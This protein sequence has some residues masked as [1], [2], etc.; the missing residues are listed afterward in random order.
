MKRT[1]IICCLLTVS[2]IHNINCQT[3]GNLYTESNADFTMSMPA[4]WQ[5]MDI[6]QKYSVI[7]GQ[8]E[9]GFT[10]NITFADDVFLGSY[11]EYID[12][13][14][15]VLEQIY[16]DLIIINRGNFSTSSGLYGEYVTLSGRMN[17]IRVR[18]KLFV[19]P[20]T[21]A[22]RIILITGS[23]PLNGERFDAIFD[24]C[25]KTFRWTR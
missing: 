2:F 20:G 15:L 23:A 21:R 25:V 10:P 6:N 8:T 19:F 14:L 13:V 7:M 18:Q 17:E 24:E 16:S 3:L 1:L 5:T 22:N 11:S 12:A 9:N 4:G